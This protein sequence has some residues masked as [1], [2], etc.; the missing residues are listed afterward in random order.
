VPESRILD[1][2]KSICRVIIQAF[3]ISNSSTE[4]H[5][6]NLSHTKS[7]LE[8]SLTNSENRLLKLKHHIARE[9]SIQKES[10]I[11]KSSD[12]HEV[13]SVSSSVSSS[14]NIPRQQSHYIRE[15]TTPEA[16]MS[17]MGVRWVI[18]VARSWKYQNMYFANPDISSLL[19][20]WSTTQGWTR[21]ARVFGC[22]HTAC[23]KP[24]GFYFLP[25]FEGNT[26]SGHWFTTI[27]H[28]MGRHRAGYVLD[29][30]GSFCT[31]SGILRKVRDMFD[32]NDATFSWTSIPVQAQ[33]E[34]EC[35]P[36][37]IRTIVSIA[38][39]I[40][41]G[42]TLQSSLDQ[43]SLLTDIGPPY[44]PDKIR[45]YTADLLRQYRTNMWTNPVRIRP[46][47]INDSQSI[48]IKQRKKRKRN[49]RKKNISTDKTP[50]QKE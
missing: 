21:I 28:K 35:G 26:I 11:D 19:S 46:A 16:F 50:S 6:D 2:H 43:A 41:L 27:I 36:R 42:H 29:S 49:Q 10:S 31:T 24:D 4:N 18:E 1:T 33:T 25:L 45:R 17:N 44:D 30:L 37:T 14:E 8:A 47:E 15:A 38:K 20:S 22:R 48:G 7:S 40:H 12:Q 5:S 3:I 32:G 9:Q 23:S 39:H 13:N 34:F